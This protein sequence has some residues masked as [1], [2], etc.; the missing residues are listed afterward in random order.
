MFLTNKLPSVHAKLKIDPDN[1]RPHNP[2][3]VCVR[4]TGQGERG[5]H[6]LVRAD[7]ERHRLVEANI[8]PYGL[9]RRIVTTAHSPD[10]AP[11]PGPSGLGR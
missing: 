9:P 6:S 11:S 2:D 8:I 5:S 10:R 1:V 3:I 7:S 4:G